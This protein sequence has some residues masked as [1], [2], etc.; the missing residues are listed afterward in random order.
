MGKLPLH[1]TFRLTTYALLAL[2]AASGSLTQIAP[3]LAC[4]QGAIPKLDAKEPSPL[5]IRCMANPEFIKPGETSTI[6]AYAG[7]PQ[8]RPLTFSYSASSGNVSG[9][10]ATAVLSSAGAPPGTVEITC[11]VSDDQGRTAAASAVV[12]IGAPVMAVRPPPDSVHAPTVTGAAPTLTPPPPPPR[13]KGAHPSSFPSDLQ[14][15]SAA[16]PAP[17]R[18]PASIASTPP[19]SSPTGQNQTA[20]SSPAPSSEYEQG[21]ALETW[22]KGLNEGHIHYSVLPSMKAQVP[23]PVTVQINGFQ[24]AAGTQPLLD[25]TGSDTLK[26]S[27]YMKVELLAPLN[28][29]EFTITPKDSDAVKFVPIDGSETWNWNVIPAYEAKNQTLEI[30][31][32]LVYRRPDTTLEDTLDDQHF[33]VNVEVQK[34]TTTVWQDFQKDPIAFIQYM[35]PGG[36]GWAALAA[37]IGS[38]GGF[39]WWKRKSRKTAAHRSRTK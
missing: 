28:P 31:V 5:E 13:K 25:E 18:Q 2:C 33:T 17:V 27:S 34:L 14:A 30:R 4:A 20:Q 7:S 32:S 15:P 16:M 38:M 21:Y 6:V 22:K 1:R 26:V 9:S 3:E 29:G 12:V 24:D 10:G 39:A 19:L 11:R 8:H 35:L 37:L 23:S 36:A